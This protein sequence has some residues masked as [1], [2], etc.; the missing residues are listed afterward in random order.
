MVR[1]LAVTNYLAQIQVQMKNIFYAQIQAISKQNNKQ[2]K[3]EFS[4]SNIGISKQNNTG[5]CSNK[6]RRILLFKYRYI[7]SRIIL[8]TIALATNE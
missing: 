1:I 3:K 7:L 2:M 4:C 5:S 6:C 8:I